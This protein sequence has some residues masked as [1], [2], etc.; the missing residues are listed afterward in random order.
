MENT[1]LQFY[2]R[3]TDKNLIE[4]VDAFGI[5]K[6]KIGFRTFSTAAE[7]GSRVQN[8]VDFYLTIPEM[9]LLCHNLLS[10]NIVHTI[11][12][13]DTVPAMYKGST[14]NNEVYSRILSFSKSN[15]GLFFTACE[16]PGK[17]NATGAVQ[18]MYK[19]NDAPN[20][21][22]IPLNNE[23]I[24]MFAIQGKRACDY[25]YAHHFGKNV[26]NNNV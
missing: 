16:G 6:I 9:D 11:N 21:V 24:K 7:K 3:K 10:G 20:K 26:Q 13:G 15:R 4:I 22:S 2:V 5:D 25:Y 1:S 14:R 23:E 12:N 8:S 19:I 17:Q 18:P